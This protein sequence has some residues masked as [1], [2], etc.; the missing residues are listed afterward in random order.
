MEKSME[1]FTFT[2]GKLDAGMAILLGERAHLIEFPSV[3]LPPGATTGS[4]VKIAVHQNH[5]EEKRRDREFW[6]LQEEILDEFGKESPEPPQLQLRNVTQTSVTL[7]WPPIKVAKAKIRS[8][9]IY[10]N[11]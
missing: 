4:I 5:A 8:L 6:D 9:D 1:S 3:L 7:Q 10:R 2:V 11:E